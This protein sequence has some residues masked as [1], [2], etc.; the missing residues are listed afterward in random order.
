MFWKLKILR[1]AGIDVFLHWSFLLA[2]IYVAYDARRNGLDWA[3]VG[4]LLILLA[5]VFGCV[6][7]HEYG[8]AL[9]ARAFGV[10]TRDIIITPIGGL[11]RL[12]GM[13]R[14]PHQEFV[15]TIAGPLV[16]LALALCVALYLALTSQSLLPPERLVGFDGFT[17][18]VLW[19]NLVLFAFNLIPAFPMDGGRILRSVLALV[20]DYRTATRIAGLMGQVLAVVAIGV[21]IYFGHY[22]LALI[23]LFVFM[24][25]AGEMAMAVGSSVQRFREVEAPA[26]T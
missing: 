24:A 3:S 17:Q 11:A 9:A 5:V 10:Q 12:S 18:L 15:V 4:V 2:P 16:N 22:S 23:G 26:E 14:K 20:T 21:G 19:L 13:P 8:H 7:L 25:A 1:A 6:L